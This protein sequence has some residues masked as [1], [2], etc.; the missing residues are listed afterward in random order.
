[1]SIF[2]YQTRKSVMPSSQKTHSDHIDLGFFSRSVPAVCHVLGAIVH[3]F[4]I[5]VSALIWP[6]PILKS[7]EGLDTPFMIGAPIGIQ[8]GISSGLSVTTIYPNAVCT[9]PSNTFR[10]TT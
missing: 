8:V 3:A 6:L 9:R 5:I 7:R 2:M 1:M 10:M 4:A